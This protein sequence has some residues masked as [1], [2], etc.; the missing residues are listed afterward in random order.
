MKLQ[1]WLER[2][3]SR[4]RFLLIALGAFGLLASGLVIGVIYRL[5][6]CPLCIFQR[7]LYIV[8]GL[9]GVYGAA[10][11]AGFR[12]NRIAAA[13]VGLAAAVGGLATAIYQTGMQLFPDRVAEC[14]FSEPTLIERLVYWLGEQWEFMFLATG[15]C[16][17]KDWTFLGLSMANWSI[18]CFAVFGALMVWTVRVN[19]GKA[20]H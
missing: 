11:P 3:T 12:K 17:S 14:G 2:L 4:Q 16:S 1:P 13:G 9:V 19:S 10:L 15:M 5:Q 20:A 7:L 8:I 6:P 18:P